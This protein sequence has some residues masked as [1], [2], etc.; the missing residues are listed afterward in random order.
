M[1]DS[2][3]SD[4]ILSKFS[5]EISK[6]SKINILEFE[7]YSI[8]PN[9][10]W[11]QRFFWPFQESPIIKGLDATFLDFNKYKH[12]QRLDRYILDN[13][14]TLNLKI[15]DN[16]IAFKPLISI[17]D[18]TFAYQKKIKYDLANLSEYDK[19]LSKLL[20]NIYFTSLNEP[21]LSAIKRHYKIITIKKDA[22]VRKLNKNLKAKIEFSIIEIHQAQYLS[23]CIEAKNLNLVKDIVNILDI[24]DTP[25]DYIAFI[26]NNI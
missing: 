17:K 3:N 7:K 9:C 1:Y 12:K 8:E 15:R 2:L 21:I 20:P 26:K 13:N 24:K 25:Q 18:N 23:L 19:E 11:E 4:S 10:K 5:L 14:Q 22:L 16:L 6:P